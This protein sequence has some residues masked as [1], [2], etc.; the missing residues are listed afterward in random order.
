MTYGLA[1]KV[2]GIVRDAG[3]HIVG[4]TRLQKIAYL[5]SISG[6]EDGLPFAYKHHGPYS[7][8]LATAARVA[9]LFGL[10]K[11][12]EQQASWGGTYSTYVVGEQ[13]NFPVHS[14]RRSLAAVAAGA[15]A[16]ELELAATAAFLF[17]EGHSDPW[18]ETARRKPEKAINGGIDRAKALYRRLSAIQTPV[19]LPPIA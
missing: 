4:R 16:I 10:V 3:G 8:A 2:A 18:G 15:D 7:E 17:K 11:E 12:T 5:L 13:S 9:N 19:A 1:E 6:L 14:A